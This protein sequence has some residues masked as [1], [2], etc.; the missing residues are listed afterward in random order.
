M[1]LV[2]EIVVVPASLVDGVIA[3]V[4]AC[5]PEEGCGLLAA[6]PGG[7]LQ[8]A[9]PT[10][11]VDRS[12]YRFTVSP[13]EHYTATKDADDHGWTIAGS[14]H[15]HPESDPYPSPTDIA[16]A[17]DASWLYVIV[18]L[19]APEAD[20]RAYRIRDG[21]VSEVRFQVTR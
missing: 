5:T 6:D 1:I 14:F 10:T 18:G 12:R 3:H 13:G 9:Y 2:T 15:S 17:L 19:S 21:V 16:G 7:G 11:N 20:V 4:I 8:M